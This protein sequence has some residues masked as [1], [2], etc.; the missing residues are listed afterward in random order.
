MRISLVATS[1]AL[2]TRTKPDEQVCCA[3]VN[4]VLCEQLQ[5]LTIVPWRSISTCSRGDKQLLS[6]MFAFTTVNMVEGLPAGF[7][8]HVY[9]TE[10]ADAAESI[11]LVGINMITAKN[12]DDC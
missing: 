4:C 12:C 6:S 7:V 8:C 1:R 11:V 10:S 9:V 5:V 3:Y 2:I